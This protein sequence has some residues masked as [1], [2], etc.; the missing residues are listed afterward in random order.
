VIPLKYYQITL[1]PAAGLGTPLKGDTLFGQFCWQAAHDPTLVEGGLD[2]C[3]SVYPERPFVVF[4]SAIVFLERPAPAFLFKRP[5][6][7]LARL[8]SVEADDC[9]QKL[10]R[11]TEG[12][13]QRW[14]LVENDLA[15]D[16]SAA[17]W[18]TDEAAKARVE[19][20]IDA[21]QR[22]RLK[23]TGGIPGVSLPFSQPHNSINRMTSTT[24]TG[25]F[26]PFA[27]DAHFYCPGLKLAVFVLLDDG[28]TDIDRVSA[29]VSRIGSWGFGRDAS[30]GMGRF[31]V[32]ATEER[33]LPDPG[34]ADACYALAP[35][36]PEKGVFQQSF[37]QP[38]TRFGKHG[39]HYARIRNPFKNPVIMADEGAVF[40][41][42][43]RAVFDKP[44]IGRAV[45][46]LSASMPKT[47][48]Q[49][50]APYL[51][52]KLER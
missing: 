1:T 52:L 4:S 51:P 43:D 33:V 10:D 3:L 19:Q 48:G 15:M 11:I 14:L 41:P 29:G 47:V 6:M 35:V 16:L 5:D 44:Y 31:N 28:L 24:G 12:K 38:F 23:R 7:P 20:A 2:Q 39:D 42:G 36:V 17:T 40:I 21:D 49:G 26:A 37:F 22:R 25:P 30:T 46:D 45:G 27:S 9:I 8:F 50:Y 34:N 13:N 18:L 32:T